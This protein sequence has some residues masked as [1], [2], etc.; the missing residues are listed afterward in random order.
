MRIRGISDVAVPGAMPP[1][2]NRRRP[3][4]RRVFLSFYLC[5]IRFLSYSSADAQNCQDNYD[6]GCYSHHDSPR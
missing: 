1:N 5:I 6:F 2:F 4:T 3:K